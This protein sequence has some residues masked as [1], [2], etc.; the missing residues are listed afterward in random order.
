MGGGNGA[1][2]SNSSPSPRSGRS[3]KGRASP[4]KSVF[5]GGTAAAVRVE[6]TGTGVEPSSLGLAYHHFFVR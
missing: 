2:S 1:P 4:R 3:K 5:G 6:G